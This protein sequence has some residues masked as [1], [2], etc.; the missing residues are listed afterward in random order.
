M[1]NCILLKKRGNMATTI[2]KKV[3]IMMISIGII[4]L[5]IGLFLANGNPLNIG[6]WGLGIIPIIAVI[7][8]ICPLCLILKRCNIN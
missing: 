4:T 8:K 1:Y 2:R 3:Q 7:F 6:W 5:L